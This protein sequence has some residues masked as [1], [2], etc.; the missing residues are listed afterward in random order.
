MLRAIWICTYRVIKTI[1]GL[2]GAIAT[3]LGVAEQWGY[4]TT[5]IPPWTFWLIAI[6]A[7]F[8]V[9]LRA[10]WQ[11]ERTEPEEINRLFKKGVVSFQEI[12]RAIHKA[13]PAYS[14]DEVL[15]QLLKAVWRGDFEEFSGH[16]R[17]RHA[18]DAFTGEPGER[19]LFKRW[20]L[21]AAPG[22]QWRRFT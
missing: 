20:E 15:H 8:A 7:L 19:P 4:A 1:G 11:L 3:A 2:I 18:V 21:F 16:T 14:E 12:T 13:H 10:Q 5:G 22:L 6:A 17:L 9:A